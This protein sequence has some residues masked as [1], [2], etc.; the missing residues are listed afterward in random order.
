MFFFDG[1][2]WGLGCGFPLLLAGD[3]CQTLVC[4][5]R[6][7]LEWPVAA[8]KNWPPRSRAL[9]GKEG[10]IIPTHFY[11]F[12]PHIFEHLGLCQKSRL[13]FPFSDTVF[14]TFTSMRF[15]CCFFFMSMKTKITQ[16]PLFMLNSPRRDLLR[17]LC[18]GKRFGEI[19][20]GRADIL[21]HIHEW[22]AD[23]NADN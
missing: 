7:N 19:A 5:T 1:R 11:N 20:G 12:L 4:R 2:I 13:F 8:E 14:E 23:L 18:F 22:S 6:T 15:Y 17:R 16:M 21:M 3:F 10:I 9:G